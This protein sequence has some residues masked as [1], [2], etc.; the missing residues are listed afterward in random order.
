MSRVAFTLCSFDGFYVG[1]SFV[2]AE[3]KL[4]LKTPME[5]S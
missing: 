1:K 2:R 4:L 3:K 5:C